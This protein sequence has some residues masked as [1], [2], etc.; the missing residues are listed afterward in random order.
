[1]AHRCCKV[2]CLY[3][4]NKKRIKKYYW[5]NE[6]GNFAATTIP[7]SLVFIIKTDMKL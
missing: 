7:E 4:F 5:P 6:V 3:F 1:M 2:F